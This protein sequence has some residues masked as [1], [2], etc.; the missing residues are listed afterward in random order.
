ME[1]PGG[2]QALAND[3]RLIVEL[4]FNQELTT[5]RILA[6]PGSL[7]RD[8]HNA[9]LLRHVGGAGARRASR[10]RSGTA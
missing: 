1:L 5:M 4:E 9:R 6:I 2:G 7:R 10:S 3:V 8:S